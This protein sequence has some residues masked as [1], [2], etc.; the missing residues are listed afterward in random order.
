[1]SGRDRGIC[2]PSG[3]T[4]SL[5]YPDLRN[6]LGMPLGLSASGLD[7]FYSES[8][9]GVG[10]SGPRKEG[11]REGDEKWTTTFPSVPLLHLL[12]RYIWQEPSTRWSLDLSLADCYSSTQGEER[13]L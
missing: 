1:M 11:G 7:T 3:T 2:W 5:L 6:D 13:G 10:G 9:D 4:I 12:L 8:G